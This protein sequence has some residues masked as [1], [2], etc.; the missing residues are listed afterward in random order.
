MK[1]Q[2]PKKK[3]SLYQERFAEDEDKETILRDVAEILSM[4]HA[5]AVSLP[6]I[7]FVQ[8]VVVWMNPSF[9]ADIFF[10]RFMVHIVDKPSLVSFDFS[11]YE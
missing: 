9:D 11:T 10:L 6:R 8:M 4:E 7:R 1:Q 3:S 5:E 2:R